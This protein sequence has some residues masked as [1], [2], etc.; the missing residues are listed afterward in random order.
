MNP[1]RTA[2]IITNLLDIILRH[3]LRWPI[4]N[5]DHRLTTRIAD[6]ETRVARRHKGYSPFLVRVLVTCRVSENM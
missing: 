6:R 3:R 4:E 1:A 5:A 2:H